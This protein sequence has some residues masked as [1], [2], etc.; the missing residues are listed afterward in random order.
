MNKDNTVRQ[1]GGFL[2]QLMPDT[3]EEVI[4]QLEE[5]LKQV[6]SVTSMLDEGMTP[7]QI[8]EMVLGNLGVEFTE[9]TETRFHCDCSKER[10]EKALISVGKTELQNMINDGEEIEVNCH[11]CNEHYKYSVDELQVMLEKASGAV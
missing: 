2:I 11:F 4:T 7:E 9:T 8:L 10:V 6:A 5:N 3:K 1:A